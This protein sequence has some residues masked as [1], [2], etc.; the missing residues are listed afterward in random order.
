[1]EGTARVHQGDTVTIGSMFACLDKPGSV[2]I[3]NI[4]PVGGVGLKVTGWGI[5]PNPFWK[6]PSPAPPI[7]VRSGWLE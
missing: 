2:T 4:A 3:T 7:G 6:E 5:R 1:L